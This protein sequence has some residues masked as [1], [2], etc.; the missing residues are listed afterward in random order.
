MQVGRLKAGLR[1]WLWSI[2]TWL[3]AFDLWA[4][5]NFPPVRLLWAAGPFECGLQLRPR[6]AQSQLDYLADAYFVVSWLTFFFS[7]WCLGQ[8]RGR[9]AS[10]ILAAV[11]RWGCPLLVAA[12]VLCFWH[13]DVQRTRFRLIQR[14]ID[15]LFALMLATQLWL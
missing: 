9:S 13:L 12:G 3:A 4:S 2:A 10:R 1:L 15:P 5:G 6:P 8:P 7:C 11:V 14:T